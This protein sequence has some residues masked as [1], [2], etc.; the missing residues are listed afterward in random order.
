MIP[1]ARNL[2][3]E[4]RVQVTLAAFSPDGSILVTGGAQGDVCVWRVDTSADRSA[5]GLQGLANQVK[6]NS[7]NPRLDRGISLMRRLCGH[8][9]AVTSLAVPQV[10][11]LSITLLP[12]HFNSSTFRHL[13]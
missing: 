5:K 3:P 13:C 1:E 7:V 6:S 8:T 11:S 9:G 12:L 4:I 2:I 10:M